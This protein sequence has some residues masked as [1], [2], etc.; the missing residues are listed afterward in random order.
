MP[1]HAID[2]KLTAAT[3][4]VRL[5]DKEVPADEIIGRP[6][7]GVAPCRGDAPAPAGA[8]KPCRT[9]QAGD[10]LLANGHTL[11]PES[12]RLREDLKIREPA[13]S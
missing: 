6:M 12:G 4:F 9:H 8:D 11:S 1:A 7:L 13:L 5:L 10:P 3:H 2:S